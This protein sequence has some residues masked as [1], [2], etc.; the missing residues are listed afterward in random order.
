[1][2]HSEVRKIWTAAVVTLLAAA[3]LLAQVERDPLAGLDASIRAAKERWQVP[4]V[5][6]A[7]V[8]DNKVL[9]AQGFGVRDVTKGGAVDA[10]TLF[11][12]GSNTKAFTATAL[13]LLVQEGKISWDDPVLRYL[14]DFQMY[15]PLV[16]R[17]ITVRDLLCHRSG[18]GTFAGDLMA[19][20]S[21]YGR[22]EVIR[23]I[24]FIEPAYDFR[25]GFGYS[26]LMFLVA[27]QIIPRV[28]GTSW[29]D[30]IRKRF[31]VP[32]GMTR[33]NTS[34][35][36]LEEATNVA[37]AH[38][39]IDGKVVP[40][41]HDSVD[42]M[43][44]AGAINSSA[45]DMARWLL[46]Q[47]GD[48]SYDGHRLVEAAV[49]TETRTLHN[50]IPVGDTAKKINP[51][52]HFSGYGLGW[53]LSDYRGRL[54]VAHTGGLNGMIS[55]VAMLPEENLGVVVLTNFDTHPLTRSITHTILDAYLGGGD[56]GWDQRYAG[57]VET[58]R[59][60]RERERKA[61]DETGVGNASPSLPV[62]AYTGHYVSDVFGGVEVTLEGGVLKLDP[63][64][65]P[66]VSGQLE[67]WQLDTFLSTW[68]DPVWDQ[69]LVY[70]DLDD[71]GK[72]SRLRFTVRPEWLD[73]M[74]Y[75]FIKQTR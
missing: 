45:N 71:S 66:G 46:L 60:R 43:A 18:L 13:G 64:S 36:E 58:L 59:D 6:V 72:V 27:G 1:M 51:W 49:I 26:N 68:T 30:F 53:G 23:R 55:M 15:D 12:I 28:T 70:F 29:D 47:T 32:L 42:N 20:G 10:D 21:I 56:Q 19:F 24:R 14:P 7:V 39:L 50:S 37:T 74:E 5:A 44:P 16:T 25:T 9:F 61:R 75:I 62:E 63:A 22:A 2:K 4:G 17:T 65:H 8:K 38:G 54:L 57:V 73:T 40:I 41:P 35:G 69:S 31:F 48:G 52:T 67:H 34:L 33:S 11:A 3:P